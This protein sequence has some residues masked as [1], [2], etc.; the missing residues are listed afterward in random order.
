MAEAVGDASAKVKVNIPIQFT[1]AL[2]T[3]NRLR[4]H[5]RNLYASNNIQ[6]NRYN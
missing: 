3:A 6:P 4:C 1:D 2:Y 5:Y